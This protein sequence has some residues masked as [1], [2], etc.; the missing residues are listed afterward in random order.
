M[1]YLFFIIFII[2]ILT[3]GTVSFGPFSLRVYMSVLM[4]AFLMFNR[5]SSKTTRNPIRVDYIYLFIVC[6]FALFLSLLVNGGLEEYGLM[7]M[8]LSHYLPCVLTY[9]AVSYFIKS[10]ADFDKLIFVFSCIIIFD[11]MVTVLQ[12]LNNPIGWGIGL[13]FS[14][15]EE[16]ESFVNYIDSHDSMM[17]VSKLT[18][19]FGH[20]VN[21]G[22]VLS[23]LTPTL[24]ARFS[25]DNRWI[26]SIY[27]FIVVILSITAC[28]LLQQRAALFLLG[29]FVAYHI[30]KNKLNRTGRI[31]VLIVLVLFFLVFFTP[32]ENGF[33]E[34]SRFSNSDN[35]AR[36]SVWNL[37]ISVFMQNILF[38]NYIQFNKMS[39]VAAHNVFIG[40]MAY[41]GIVGLIPVVLL[42]F[43]TIF[44]SLKVMHSKNNYAKVFSYGVLISMMMGLFHNTS[45][46]SGEVIIF[47]LLALMFKSSIL[48]QSYEVNRKRY[49]FQKAV[50]T[51]G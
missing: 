8:C 43:K 33:L 20:P 41:S 48:L 40:A 12:Y 45:Y 28:L 18:G 16:I 2:A 51:L 42:Y 46:L 22:F 29:L 6:V 31:I 10:K 1:L 27:Y 39:D 15:E 13:L 24:M 9:F 19:I 47:L 38:G 3:C 17:G 50:Q 35:S 4:M 26:V 21:N 11:S 36:T 37:G 32:N 34:S 25:K 7:K 30:F 5:V 23:V 49:P 14:N 44:D